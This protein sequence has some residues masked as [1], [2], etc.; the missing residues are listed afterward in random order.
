MKTKLL[1]SVFLFIS[2]F[3]FGQSNTNLFRFGYGGGFTGMSTVY[4][5]K[6]D[7]II[8]KE[9]QDG[10]VVDFKKISDTKIKK[11]LKEAKKIKLSTYRLSEPGNIYFFITYES[12]TVTWGNPAIKTPKKINK[13][14]QKLLNEVKPT[15]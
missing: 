6:S 9:N 7:G 4:I 13:F 8:Q 14:Y 1:I 5:L 10:T 15:K 11:F 12:N 3:S 2:C